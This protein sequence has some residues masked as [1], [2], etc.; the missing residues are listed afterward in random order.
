MYGS[1]YAQI[2]IVAREIYVGGRKKYYMHTL[3]SKSRIIKCLSLALLLAMLLCSCGMFGKKSPTPQQ[4]SAETGQQGEKIPDQLKKMEESIEKIFKELN[5]PSVGVKEEEAPKGGQKDKQDQGGK[6]Q[7]GAKSQEKG[8]EKK[9]E[10]QSKQG[11]QQEK[12]SAPQP[13]QPAPPDPWEKINTI[14]NDLHYQWNAYT[15]MAL[16]N[17]A[18]KTLLDNFGNAL[19]NLTNTL[20]SKNK[21]NAMMAT[22]N[23]YGYIPDFYYLYKTKSSPE[24][25]K[26]RHYTRSSMLNGMSG[27]WAQADADVNNM[28][29]SWTIYKNL[30]PND[31]QE[32]VGKLDFAIYEYE[33]V[34]KEKNQ[35][36]VDIKGRVV[37]SDIEALE[38]AVE[39]STKKS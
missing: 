9:E 37:M 24:I 3:N 31:Q 8:G 28:K 38:K 6:G 33:K 16:K 25:K 18:N 23:L 13:V 1:K 35:Q 5:G 30:A 17:G 20:N 26:I 7:E 10:G 22:S 39:E 21:M 34:V 14:V 29:S 32:A 2:P 12:P 4:Q 27:N 19:N 11:G 15:P 36:L